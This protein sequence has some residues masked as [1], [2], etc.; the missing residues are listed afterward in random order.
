[1]A[2]LI[3]WR[4]RRE[5]KQLLGRRLKAAKQARRVQVED[6]WA[7]A[8]KCVFGDDSQGSDMLTQAGGAPD[9]PDFD[10]ADRIDVQYAFRNLRLIHSH[11]SSNPP[12]STARAQSTDLEDR[13]A[14]KAAQHTMRWFLQTLD[15]H[16]TNDLANLDCLVTGTGVTYT[17]FD[18]DGGEPIE[19]NRETCEIKTDGAI[20]LRR[21]SVDAFWVDPAAR[22]D[23]S[24]RWTFEKRQFTGEEARSRWPKKWQLIKRSCLHRVDNT[25]PSSGTLGTSTNE[26]NTDAEPLYDLYWYF[27]PGAPENGFLG[28]FCICA[29]DGTPIV[30]PDIN[31]N[32]SYPPPALSDR[33]RAAA[34]GQRLERK[35]PTAYSPYQI[36]TDID[37]PDRFWGRSA[38]YY[39]APAQ[40]LMSNLDS[41]T[42]E[43]MR[44]HGVV[45]LVL[46][47][48]A[49]MAES[50]ITNSSVEII[51]Q[52]ADSDAQGEPIGY[53]APA[54]LPNS[55]ADLRQL[56]RQGV[57]DM[58]GVNENM[59]GQQSREQSAVN[60]QYAV[61]QGVMVRRRLFNKSIR[62]V[63]AQYKALLSL[64]IQ[65]WTTPRALAVLGEESAY[66]V[67]EFMNMDLYCGYE[68][69]VEYG[70]HLPLDP[71][72]RRDELMK[73]MPIYE[74]L[75]ISK[76]SIASALKIADLEYV[77]EL[78][79]LSRDR[80]EEVVDIIVTKGIQVQPASE[81]QDHEGVLA[82]LLE[83]VNTSS[84]DR[85]PED[86]R[87]LIDDHIRI[88]RDLAA[89]AR[90]EAGAG[91]PTPDA[92]GAPSA[93]APSAA[94]SAPSAGAPELAPAPGGAL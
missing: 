91:A 58:W 6:E 5:V 42:M 55:M 21:V 51:E 35:P 40:R 48:G 90:A 12:V 70:T 25:S 43:A 76:R 63:R 94:I 61:N 13:R 19:F 56:M 73:M 50:A 29:E 84:F 49:K 9:T 17:G 15:M 71:L 27:E 79:D 44:A 93:A 33:R 26:T 75:G 59:F 34:T 36:V 53:M 66:D 22:A 65:H 28:R 85:L 31:P 88:R 87:F 82:Y 64:A 86:R 39:V 10:L 16:N 47:P 1:M 45:R 18:A 37:V 24:I 4:D 52:A 30:G 78:G 2:K 62:F 7:M 83:Y 32:L 23:D 74:Q 69:D 11:M 77:Q 41:A 92:V 68:I 67:E 14:A 80:A 46:P 3:V 20:E 72:A 89:A 81:F 54:G 60:M 38:L 8:R 57:D